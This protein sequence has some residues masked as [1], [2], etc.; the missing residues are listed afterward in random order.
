M[1]QKGSRD[2][3]FEIKRKKEKRKRGLVV[4]GVLCGIFCILFIPTQLKIWKMEGQL[5]VYQQQEQELLAQ[6][7]DIQKEID[8]YSSDAYIEER[9]REEL[10]LVKPGES[11]IRQA[12]PGRVQPSSENEQEILH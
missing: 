2:R 6:K 5:D 11:P 12:V 9:A 8:Y 10:G 3:I 4:L 1:A 7:E